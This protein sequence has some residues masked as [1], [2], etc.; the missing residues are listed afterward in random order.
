ML[1]GIRSKEATVNITCPCR[2]FIIQCSKQSCPIL[3]NQRQHAHALRI[4]YSI[5]DE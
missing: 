3:D 1:Q 4:E 2:R 5:P